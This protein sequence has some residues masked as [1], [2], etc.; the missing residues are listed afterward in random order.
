MDTKVSSVLEKARHEKSKGN[1]QKAAKRLSD[2]ITKAPEVLEL[3]LEA[4]DACLE[5][6]ESLQATQFLKRSYAKFRAESERIDAYASEKLK[7]T[8]DPVLGKFLLEQAI[9]KKA[10]ED[11]T[12]VLDALRDRTVSELLQRTRNKKQSLTSA[13]RGG[14]ALENE[15]VTNLLCESLLCLRLG[16]MKEAVRGFLRILDEKPVEN[17]VFEP[18]FAH[19]EKKYPKA[20]RIRFAYACSLIHSQEYDQ[21]MSR[22]VQSVKMDPKIGEDG[23]KLLRGLSD[24]S[25]DLPESIQG[26]LVEIL[27]VTGGV[28]QAAELLGEKLKNTPEKAKSVI[29]LVEPYINDADDGCVLRFLYVDA[30]LLAKQTRRALDMLKRTGAEAPDGI[31]LFGWLEKKSEEQFLPMEILVYLGELAIGNKLFDRAIE[32]FDAVLNNSPADGPTVT[33]LVQKYKDLDPRLAEFWEAHGDVNVQPAKPD[34]D[35]FEFEHF[36]NNEFLFSSG[37]VSPPQEERAEMGP[38]VFGIEIESTRPEDQPAAVLSEEVARAESPP[39]EPKDV[40]NL[41]AGLSTD[42]GADTIVWQEEDSSGMAD[43]PVESPDTGG[44]TNDE[45]GEDSGADDVS[46]LDANNGDVF[47]APDEGEADSLFEPGLSLEPTVSE[48][49][50]DSIEID[51]VEETRGDGEDNDLDQNAPDEREP[52]ACHEI[53]EDYVKNVAGAIREAGAALFFHIDTGGKTPPADAG[54]HDQ[55]Q[56][57]R[58]APAEEVAGESPETTRFDRR[59]EDFLRG[60]LDNTAV[61]TLLQEALADG[62]I[63][64]LRELLHFEP[65]TPE[66]AYVQTRY[67]VDYFL[68]RGLPAAALDV[69]ASIDLRSLTPERKKE[70]LCKKAACQTEMLDFE[71]AHRTYLKLLKQCPS[72]EVST[73]AKRNYDQYLRDQCESNPVLI[74][75]TSLHEE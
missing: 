52:S 16:R 74:K 63:D 1:Y 54:G 69:L 22:L 62:K 68:C 24:T 6:G 28:S 25:Q 5:G 8:D 55:E 4:A 71:S 23:L 65:A 56:A 18:F 47:P 15:S 11:A 38:T 33:T 67:R 26:A 20:G 17:E 3:Y 30:A 66:E 64:E 58:P 73:M 45:T 50:L 40:T 32:I 48:H 7:S 34:A 44:K 2:A 61:L 37:S 19:L 9:K 43:T 29:E 72:Q 35:G 42:D 59:F 10:L 41:D 46:W 70:V 12:E 49:S 21:A 27:L 51:P 60:E 36:E 14:H 53:D 13:S 39:G 57:G 75:T 31:D